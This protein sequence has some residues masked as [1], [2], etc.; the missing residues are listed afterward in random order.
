MPDDALTPLIEGSDLAGLM[1]AVDG[2]CARRDWEALIDLR[3]RCE[4]AV[5]RGKQVW[6][7]AQFAEYRLA[8]EGPADL[9]A[10]VMTDGRG[11]FALGPLWEVA[12][13]SH[14]WV[15]LSPHVQLPTVRAMVGHE[16]SIR[17]DTVGEDEIDGAVLGIPVA[18]QPW[19]PAYP[20]A[21]YRSDRAAFPDDVF[22]LPMAWADMPDAASA[23]EDDAVCDILL[24]LV[25]PWWEDSQ[26]K[27]E[28]ITVTGNV[29]SAIRALGR[30]RARLLDVDP[31][32]AMAAMAWA[33]ASGGGHGRRR[34]TP[35][36]RAAA[37]WV[38]LEVLG[39]G[40]APDDPSGIGEEA[41][42]LRWVLWDP[43]DRVGGWN[44][45]IGIEDPDDGIAWVLSAV[46]AL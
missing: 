21:E 28:V 30:S 15:E 20:T 22:D 17:G 5:T 45:H 18:V 24:D 8:L 11:R 34:G 9:A 1:R 6:A 3:D 43:G 33:G 25:K 16:R 13:S 2:I 27:A 26:G 32:T 44:L 37:W 41:A 19:E 35:A 23:D 7:I 40:E 39:H 12:A 36:G 31:A 14:T 10:S 29:E 46:D 4:E 38:I 42:G